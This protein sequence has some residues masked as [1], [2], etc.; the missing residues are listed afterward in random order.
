MSG[1]V[2]TKD[3]DRINTEVEVDKGRK[4]DKMKKAVKAALGGGETFDFSP[5]PGMAPAPK[6]AKPRKS[7]KA[8]PA[9][10]EDDISVYNDALRAT[11]SAKPNKTKD[12]LMKERDSVYLTCEL[13]WKMSSGEILDGL[14]PPQPTDSLEQLKALRETIRG[15]YSTRGIRMQ[16]QKMLEIFFRTAEYVVVEL[17]YDPLGYGDIR[18]VHE[19]VTKHPDFFEDE[20][21]EII[22]E[23][24]GWFKTNCYM[25][26]AMKLH[27]LMQSYGRRPGASV[28]E[29]PPPVAAPAPDVEALREQFEDL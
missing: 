24:A 7:A 26:F 8:K 14:R 16:G 3:L 13:Y 6:A 5:I 15:R 27:I 19:M 10:T 9:I 1:D 18:G 2:T 25:R 17:G 22:A 28:A 29:A 11:P 20:L 4:K 23:N 21:T 12:A